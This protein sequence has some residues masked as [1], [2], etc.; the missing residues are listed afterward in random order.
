MYLCMFQRGRVDL[1]QRKLEFK[2]W[3]REGDD[4]EK[5]GGTALR[6]SVIFHIALGRMSTLEEFL[7]QE[8]L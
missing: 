3:V 4:I 8:L 7:I 2:S 5:A 1:P 6:C